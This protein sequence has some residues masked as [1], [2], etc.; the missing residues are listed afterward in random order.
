MGWRTQK[1]HEMRYWIG[2]VDSLKIEL[3]WGECGSVGS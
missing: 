2:E 3:V 1:S